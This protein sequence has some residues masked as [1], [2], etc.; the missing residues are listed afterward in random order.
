VPINTGDSYDW[1]R[2]A[3]Y[4]RQSGEAWC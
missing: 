3:N 2:I 4:A 1:P